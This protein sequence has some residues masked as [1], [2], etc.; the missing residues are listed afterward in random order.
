MRVRQSFAHSGQRR[1]G[2]RS[3]IEAENEGRV[4]L[5]L[6]WQGVWDERLLS[7]NG[8]H[9]MTAGTVG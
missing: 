7:V 6:T 8:P 4:E 5:N 3:L 1:D 9:K 2:T